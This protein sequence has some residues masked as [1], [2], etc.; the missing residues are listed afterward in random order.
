MLCGTVILGQERREL[1]E[2]IAGSGLSRRY[3]V[4]LASELMTEL[5]CRM[6]TLYTR[7]VMR[8]GIISINDVLYQVSPDLEGQKVVVDPDILQYRTTSVQGDNGPVPLITPLQPGL[9]TARE[10]IVRH[11]DREA[12]VASIGLPLDRAVQDQAQG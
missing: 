4:D 5:G 10:I 3:V 7:R 9:L 6:H 1:L 2:L 11:V 12:Q 8:D